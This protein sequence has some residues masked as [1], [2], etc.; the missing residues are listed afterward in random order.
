MKFQDLILLCS[1][2]YF[3]VKKIFSVSPI[4]S[5]NSLV[6]TLNVVKFWQK[7][8]SKNKSIV[9]VHLVVELFLGITHLSELIELRSIVVGI[10]RKS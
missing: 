1:H 6:E 4:I 9:F 7:A 2:A 5:V 8:T 3:K 10:C